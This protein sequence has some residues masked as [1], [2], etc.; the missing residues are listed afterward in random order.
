LLLPPDSDGDGL[1]DFDEITAGTNP[2]GTD[3]D[4]DGVADP[5]DAFPLDPARSQPPSPTP[6]D[7]TPPDIFLDEPP[8]ATPLP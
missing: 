3:T 5:L 2:F 8:A 4:G 1:N 7:T 6:G